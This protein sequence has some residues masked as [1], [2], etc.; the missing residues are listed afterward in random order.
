MQRWIIA[1]LAGVL[2]APL[3]LHAQQVS[4]QQLQALARHTQDLQAVYA[5]GLEISMEMDAA[6]ALIDSYVAGQVPEAEMRGRVADVRANVTGAIGA[7]EAAI[8]ALPPR[9]RIGDPKRDQGLAAF[10]DMVR[11]LTANLTAQWRLLERLVDTAAS[12]DRTAYDRASADS[13]ALAG[14]LIDAE[15]T[16]IEAALLGANPGHPQR[17]LYHASIGSN[18]AVRAALIL[19][20][21]SLRGGRTRVADARA[22]IERGLERA[23]TG[24]ENGRRDADAMLARLGNGP[25]RTESDR[26]GKQFIEDLVAGYHRAFDDETRIVAAMRGFLD[27]LLAAAE[28]PKSEADDRLTVAAR[29]FQVEIVAL[30]DARLA[31]QTRRLQLVE[32]FSAALAATQ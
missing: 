32:A 30:I 13:L 17:G 22:A 2:L 11:G 9:P 24:I 20:E 10:E 15:N 3:P 4:P 7:Y 18:L 5:Q 26:L 1:V 28:A 29:T 14:T 25:A 31:G 6:E 16:A 19:L 8:D 21:D 12:G 23:E 27:N